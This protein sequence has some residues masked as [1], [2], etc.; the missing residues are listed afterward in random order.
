MHSKQYLQHC[1]KMKII[2]RKYINRKL[3][4]SILISAFLCLFGYFSNNWPLFTGENLVLHSTIDYLQHKISIF[5]ND[6]KVKA[7]FVNTSFDKQLIEVYEDP[8]NPLGNTEITDRKKLLRFLKLLSNTDYGFVVLD[9]RF[10][11]SLLDKEHPELDKELFSYIKSMPRCIV[12]THKDMKIIGD[13]QAKSAL[14]DYKSTITSTNFVRY[15]Y[16]DSIPTIPLYIY[17]EQQKSKGLDTICYRHEKFI[18]FYHEGN[19]LCQNSVF[20]EF[21]CEGFGELSGTK[22]FTGSLRNIQ[23]YNYRNLGQHYVNREDSI[24]ALNFL[25]ADLNKLGD[26]AIVFVGNMTEDLHDT[27]AG[28]QPGMVILNNAIDALSKGRH[29]VYASHQAIMF[30]VYLMLSLCILYKKGISDLLPA[31][32]RKK[33][34]FLSFMLQMLSLTSVLFIVELSEIK[35]FHTTTNFFFTLLFFAIMKFY[36][37][38]NDYKNMIN[39]KIRATWTILIFLCFFYQPTHAQKDASMFYFKI[40]R[41]SHHDVMINKTS[42][43]SIK[44]K[45]GKIRATDRITWNNDSAWID[46]YP[47]SDIFYKEYKGNGEYQ[48]WQK[49]DVRRIVFSR[50]PIKDKTT[51]IYWW[52]K[53]NRTSSK[54]M[55][56]DIFLEYEAYMI[57]DTILIDDFC[58]PIDDT[59]NYTLLCLDDR[60]Q[61]YE[62]KAQQ[63]K[64]STSFFFT[65]KQLCDID[66]KKI[67]FFELIY[68][69]NIRVVEYLKIVN[70]K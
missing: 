59:H 1:N 33:H 38:F 57:N 13:L 6:E 46:I 52:L 60:G 10:D 27:Y 61:R 70:V 22:S 65:R 8:S 29:Y 37:E 25:K 20:L 21:S 69:R 24:E 23:E 54:S 44:K 42:A 63:Y 28:L 11:E 30:I 17:N 62:I 45:N 12:A 15:E 41:I 2:N 56:N 3:I 43:K 55:S 58:N 66:L 36:I 39:S 64:K 51:D 40:D 47:L 34:A 18:N 67:K 19:A 31:L 26:N 14:A 68:D 48:K 9:I 50:F 53:H 35:M 5:A 16:F 49:Y 32:W 4:T 7:L